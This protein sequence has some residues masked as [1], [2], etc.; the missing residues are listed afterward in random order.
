[1]AEKFP[2]HP[3]TFAEMPEPIYFHYRTGLFDGWSWAIE[4]AAEMT[5]RV[6]DPQGALVAKNARTWWIAMRYAIRRSQESETAE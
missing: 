6:R 5:Y 4:S 3:A 1:M 2:R